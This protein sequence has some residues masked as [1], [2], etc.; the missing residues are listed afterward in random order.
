M[1]KRTGLL[2]AALWTVFVVTGCHRA[3]SPSQVDKDIAAAHQK[4]AENTQKAVESAQSR[5]ATARGDVHSA[6]RNEA[7]VSAVESQEV[8][9]SEAEGAHN[10]ALAACESLNG[11]MQ[12]SCRDKA[13]ADYQ[14]AKARAEQ[15]RVASDPKP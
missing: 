6:Q 7:H 10:V 8:A 11:A 2:L 1:H 5:L 3:E 13:D 15:T 12:K 4:A 14:V 9:D